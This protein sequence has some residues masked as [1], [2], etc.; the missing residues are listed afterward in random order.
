MGQADQDRHKQDVCVGAPR[1]GFTAFL[2]GLPH[3]R[4]V[5]RSTIHDRDHLPV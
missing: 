1:D 3:G 2:S 4:T 5:R